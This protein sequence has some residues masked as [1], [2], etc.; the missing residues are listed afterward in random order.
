MAPVSTVV[1]AVMLHALLAETEELLGGASVLVSNNVD[2][3]D[4]HNRAIIERYPHLA[5]PR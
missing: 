2:G 4:Q 1:G 5:G 3:G